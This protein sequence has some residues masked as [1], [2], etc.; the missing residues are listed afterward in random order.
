[1]FK[2]AKLKKEIKRLRKKIVFIEKKLSRSQAALV[3]AILSSTTPSDE[4]TDYF[5]M[6]TGQIEDTRNKMHEKQAELAAL[7]GKK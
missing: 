6:Y 4:D 7:N 2:K 5:N 1:M 3:T